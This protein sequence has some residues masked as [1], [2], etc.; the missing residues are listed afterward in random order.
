MPK[1]ALLQPTRSKSP[2]HDDTHRDLR[3]SRGGRGLAD[4][5]GAEGAEGV[6]GG[7]KAG[8]DGDALHLAI[9]KTN[10]RK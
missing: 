4:G 10:N 5:A 2:R 9:F 1:S 8:E 3:D 7:Q 6:G